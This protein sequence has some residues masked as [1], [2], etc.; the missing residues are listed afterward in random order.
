MASSWALVVSTAVVWVS[1]GSAFEDEPIIEQR[2]INY[3]DDLRKAMLQSPV[4]LTD[5]LQG[6][7]PLDGVPMPRGSHPLHFEPPAERYYVQFPLGR[8]TS[9]NLQSICANGD[10]RPR[11][12]KSYFPSSGFSGQGR[13]GS[14]V[15]KAEAWFSICCNGNPTWTTNVTLC[16]LTRAWEQ[17]IKVY[18]REEFSIKTSHFHCCKER[19][20]K[21]LNC[22]NDDAPNPDYEPTEEIPMPPLQSKAKFKFDPTICQTPRYAGRI[23]A[24]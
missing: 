19:G 21:R 23:G 17:S 4:D 22:F 13:K 1:L 7:V 18:C 9:D 5:L 6:G 24:A 16:C 11:Y 15:N 2:E 10:R 12:P 8:P 20:D 3:A 14:S